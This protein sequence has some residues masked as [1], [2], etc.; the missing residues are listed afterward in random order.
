MKM[1][2]GA[3]N[4]YAGKTD[5]IQDCLRPGYVGTLV[6]TPGHLGPVSS[7]GQVA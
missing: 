4:Y 3:I 2:E 6:I 7:P 5:I 1:K